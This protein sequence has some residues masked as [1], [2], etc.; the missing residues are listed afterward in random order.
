MKDDQ[1]VQFS[2]ANTIQYF[3]TVQCYQFKPHSSHSLDAQLAHFQLCNFGLD[4][5]D[6]F[7]GLANDVLAA[8]RNEQVAANAED[9]RLWA[10]VE[11]LNGFG[12]VGDTEIHLLQ[13]HVTLLR[14]FQ[15]S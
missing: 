2:N 13:L 10:L 11:L 5:A 9:F 7:L 12:H 6:L 14:C 3:I 4:L 15:V 1:Y 8:L